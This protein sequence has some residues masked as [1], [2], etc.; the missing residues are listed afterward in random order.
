M[1]RTIMSNWLADYHHALQL[2]VLSGAVMLGVL[3]LGPLLTGAFR[4]ARRFTRHI[5]GRW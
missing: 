2:H 4:S 5:Q 1:L 3:C